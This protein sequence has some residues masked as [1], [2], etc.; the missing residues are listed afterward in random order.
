MSNNSNSVSIPV[1]DNELDDLE[2]LRVRVRRKRKKPGNRAK[3]DLARRV[4]RVML[5]YWLVVFV[6]LA[7]ALLLFEASRIGPKSK[8]GAKSEVGGTT[9]PKLDDL[10]RGTEKKLG[11][12][13][14]PDGNL[15]RLDPVTRMVAGVRKRK[16]ATTLKSILIPYDLFDFYIQNGSIDSCDEN[17]F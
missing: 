16:L 1:S 10:K 17:R 6:L 4:L 7:A 14:K 5:R 13:D 2:R 11:L 15:N 3:N 9:G 8:L 12:D